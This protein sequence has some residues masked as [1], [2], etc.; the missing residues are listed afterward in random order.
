[1]SVISVSMGVTESRGRMGA[2]RSC[3]RRIRQGELHETEFGSRTEFKE[4]IN[5]KMEGEKQKSGGNGID[6][7]PNAGG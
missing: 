5:S 2:V 3:W 7:L 1:M 4:R 6:E